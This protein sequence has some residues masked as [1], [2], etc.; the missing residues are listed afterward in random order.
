MAGLTFPNE[1][2][3]YRQK[4]NQLLSAEIDLRARV[5]RVA[6]MRRALP[7][8]G[9]LKED[10]AFEEFDAKGHV[11]TVKFS[12]LFERG[13]PSLFLYS[14]MYGPK[15]ENPCPMC[16]SFLDG[17]NGNARHITQ[18]LNLAVVARSP[19]QRIV[20]FARARGWNSL[21]LLSSAKNNYHLDYFGEGADGDQYP[22]ANVFTRRNGAIY[23]FWGTELL[24]ADLGGETRHIDMMWPLWNVFDTTPE[25]RSTDWHPEL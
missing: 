18:R 13:K 24:F 11:R 19:I 22:M 5:E 12:E 3:D 2:G 6:A 14:F 15:M 23:H 16:S 9:L 4:R 25:G 8:G 10:Y 20:T 21:R 1:T 17:L 7:P